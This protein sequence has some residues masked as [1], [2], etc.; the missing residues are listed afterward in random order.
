MRIGVSESMRP[1]VR[2]ISLDNLTRK[3]QQDAPTTRI[4]PESRK[5]GILS[6]ELNFLQQKKENLVAAI[7]LATEVV[8][9]SFFNKASPVF[10]YFC[11]FF[12]AGV[13]G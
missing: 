6:W 3:I 5:L 4:S 2:N 9:V 13:V 7:R 8:F 12:I 10:N 1:E 11:I